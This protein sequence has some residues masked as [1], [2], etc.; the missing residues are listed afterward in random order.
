M[1]KYVKLAKI[2]EGSYGTVYRC[3]NKDTNAIVAIKKFNETEDDA[4]IKKIAM[5][6]IKMLK[7]ISWKKFRTIRDEWFWCFLARQKSGRKVIFG[8]LVPKL[9][10][11]KL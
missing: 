11:L 6:E 3:R 4:Q 10:V 1:D 8:Q 5:R 9:F 2:G 7:V